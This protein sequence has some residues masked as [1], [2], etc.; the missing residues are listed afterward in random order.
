M[1]ALF[2]ETPLFAVVED[3]HRVCPSAEYQTPTSPNHRAT[4][5]SNS[6]EEELKK[7]S[8]PV[9]RSG[10][11]QAKQH[12][13]E[14]S[15]LDDMQNT[16]REA[17]A[18]APSS[19]A[20]FARLFDNYPHPP[21]AVEIPAYYP[22][23]RKA[24]NKLSNEQKQSAQLTVQKASG[25]RWLGYWL[26]DGPERRGNLGSPPGTPMERACGYA[27]VHP[28]LRRGGK[29][30]A[31]PVGAFL[32]YNAALA[33][34][35]RP[36]GCSKANGRRILTWPSTM[37]GQHERPSPPRSGQRRTTSRRSKRCL[38]PSS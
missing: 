6:M 27:K 24:W 29:I 26:D 11:A 38:G 1:V 37:G 30:T 12:Q 31:Q 35:C 28:N 4:A 8:S 19:H 20:S 5:S 14:E 25:E 18:S 17:A 9:G 16:T 33:D 3:D 7:D 13:A 2:D 21:G 23:A 22:H 34:S 10:A 32:Q 36:A 15:A